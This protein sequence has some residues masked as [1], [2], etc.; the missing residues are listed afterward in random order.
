M[1]DEA[2]FDA[3]RDLI[4]GDNVE[5]THADCDQ[6]YWDLLA[7]TGMYE[8]DEHED[9]W[10]LFVKATDHEKPGMAEQMTWNEKQMLM[11]DM[12]RILRVKFGDAYV[13]TGSQP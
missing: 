2:V 8:G 6:R 10:W 11:R 4:F 9:H 12:R 3:I 7:D 5:L 1:T 13:A